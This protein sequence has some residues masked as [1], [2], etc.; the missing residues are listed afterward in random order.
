VNKSIVKFS[1]S[2]QLT[3]R[4]CDVSNT[5]EVR[6]INDKDCNKAQASHT[7]VVWVWVFGFGFGIKLYPNQPNNF[8]VEKSICPT[9]SA[10]LETKEEHVS[11]EVSAMRR[12]SATSFSMQLLRMLL[13]PKTQASRES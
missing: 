4:N 3:S 9:V 5:T 7:L 8:L 12:R 11:Y 2:S 6:V 10:S 13:L 1:S